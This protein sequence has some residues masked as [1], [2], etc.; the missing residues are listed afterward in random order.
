MR[1]RVLLL[2]PGEFHSPTWG[3][4]LELKP[5]LVYVHSFLKRFL[6]VRVLDLENEFSRPDGPEAL[7]AFKARALERVLAEDADY[8]AISCW[9]SLNYLP[10]RYFAEE[11]K[12]SRPQTRVIVGGF[13]PTFVPEDFAYPGHPFDHV[14]G[15]EISNILPVFPGAPPGPG[16]T[17]EIEPDF[18]SYPYFAAQRTVG[19]YLGSGCPFRCSFCMEYK[20]RWSVLP[21]DRALG[22]IA[23]VQEQVSPR[24]IVFFDACFGLDPGWRREFLTRLAERNPDNHFWLETRVDLI[25]EKDL[26]LLARL[27]VKL[28]FGV[29]SFSETM[30]RIMRKTGDPSSYLEKFVA[31][32]RKCSEHGILH[33]VFLIFNHP[34]E[35]R[36]TYEQFKSFM[37]SRVVEELRGGCLRV[38]FQRF[39]LFPGS[40]VFNHLPEYEQA[41]GFSIQ[42]PKWWLRSENHFL[43]SRAITPSRDRDGRPYSVPLK[44][45]SGLVKGFNRESREKELWQRLRAFD[46]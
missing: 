5:H 32:S 26:E 36:E 11:V 23:A 25:E 35:T 13:H 30:L 45:I 40:Q 7:E 16:A 44:E 9:S 27:K 20:R 28:D 4:F 3:R 18:R 41:Y 46:L 22:L 12:R 21:V 24:Y 39:A 29:D 37:S 17:H 15:G 2:Y 38:L 31:L 33:D 19:V 43:A 14:I 42:D 6:D 34:G 1:P 8:L 10:T